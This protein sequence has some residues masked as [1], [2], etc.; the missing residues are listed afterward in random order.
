MRII[1]SRTPARIDFAGGWS[2]V[3]EFCSAE[4][5]GVVVNAAISLYSY[6][7]II[8]R[9]PNSPGIFTR[10]EDLSSGIEFNVVDY[11]EKGFYSLVAS[12]EI[13]SSAALLLESA[14]EILPKS[15]HAGLSVI[16][17]SESPPGSGL[18]TSAAMG[19]GLVNALYAYRGNSIPARFVL[20][21]AASDIERNRLHILGG[22]QDQYASA[23]GG[24]SYM[25]FHGEHVQRE[26]IAIPLEAK[27]ELEHTLLLCYTDEPRL[28]GN[29]HRAVTDGY[30]SSHNLQI[31]STIAKL[32]EEAE[33]CADALRRNDMGDFMLAM[34]ANWDLQKKLAPEVSNARMERALSIAF[35]NGARAGKACGAGGGGCLLF[36]CPFWTRHQVAQALQ[37]DGYQILSFHFDD[38]GSTSWSLSGFPEEEDDDDLD[39]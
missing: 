25:Q 29:I 7:T 6:V 26:A 14:K 9:K 19:V 30:R 17:E 20:A 31:R 15:Q 33:K 22:K 35:A 16:T 37:S 18:G 13:D 28:S 36:Y 21:E 11:R 12:Q 8:R 34:N 10:V 24:F 38:L 1:R 4:N 39:S 32:A 27:L 2:D 23:Y 5:P 3:P